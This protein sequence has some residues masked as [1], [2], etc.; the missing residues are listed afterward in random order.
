MN[1]DK[2]GRGYMV[3]E[4]CGWDGLVLG[5]TWDRK[6]GLVFTCKVLGVG[7]I[8]WVAFSWASGG[9]GMADDMMTGREAVFW[10][11][12]MVKDITGWIQRG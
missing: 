1:R 6:S 5:S 12:V 7:W 9:Y 10:D 8:G 3:Y 4:C 2:Q 11:N